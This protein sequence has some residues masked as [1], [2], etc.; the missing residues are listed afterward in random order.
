MRHVTL[1]LTAL[2]VLA[3]IHAGAAAPATP[4]LTRDFDCS[5]LL[6]DE[7]ANAAAGLELTV[8]E[9]TA[10]P[11]GPRSFACSWILG[12]RDR[13]RGTILLIS[14]I[15]LGLRD[16]R[17]RNRTAACTS[18]KIPVPDL[19]REALCDAA[20]SLL[21]SKTWR[22]A[23]ARYGEY[24]RRLMPEASL[25][26]GAIPGH[27]VQVGYLT[28]YSGMM[29][30]MVRPGWTVITASCL[31]ISHRGVDAQRRGKDCERRALKL[32]LTNIRERQRDA[33]E[34]V[35]DTCQPPF[36]Q[37]VPKTRRR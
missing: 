10:T 2:V 12:S 36:V 34:A 8:G 23:F 18:K 35:A 22:E 3:A 21:Q 37:P 20:T 27:P 7:D 25:E 5:P 15:D 29:F 4:V 11:L 26:T 16:N 31:E 24:L 1:A 33:C 14:A 17:A 30:T 19:Q 6:S 28:G 32:M 9:T 13:K